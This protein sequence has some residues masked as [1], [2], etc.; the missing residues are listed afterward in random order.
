ME[1]FTQ[2]FSIFPANPNSLSA[3]AL[4]PKRRQV[5]NACINCQKACKKCDEGRP[6]QRCVKYGLG[7]TCRDS[8]R[9]ERR[10][11]ERRGP[12]L[13]KE[14]KPRYTTPHNE[15]HFS[16]ISPNTAVS[17]VQALPRNIEQQQS[18]Q[19][20]IIRRSTSPA[21][22]AGSLSDLLRTPPPSPYIHNNTT[23]SEDGAHIKANHEETYQ[24]FSTK[25][26]MLNNELFNSDVKTLDFYS[27]TTAQLPSLPAVQTES[28]QDYTLQDSWMGSNLR[29]PPLTNH[30]PLPSIR[31]VL[32]SIN[33]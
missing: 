27:P 24:R 31:E 16:I 19:S 10:K 26:P 8:M 14:S 2:T 11:G 6:C 29:L 3:E 22:S 17:K 5:K 28:S 1:F 21:S 23:H 4:R 7:D 13:K 32:S 15:P 9:K 25:A 18:Q 33:C 12:Y 30:V 20:E